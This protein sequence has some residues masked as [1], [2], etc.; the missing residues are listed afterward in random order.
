MRKTKRV[1]CVLFVLGFLLGTLPR[2]G[3]SADIRDAEQEYL[4]EYKTPPDDEPV[5]TVRATELEQLLEQDAL[6]WYEPDTELLL[7]D[8]V[9]PTERTPRRSVPTRW[10]L[11]MIGASAAVDADCIG[12]GVRVG[13]IDSG[14]AAHPDL[15]EN[16]VPG[17]NYTEGTADPSDT[18]DSY[19]HGTRVAGLISGHSESSNTGA[20]PG[21]TIVPLKCTDGKTVRVS[22]ICRAIYGGVDDFDCDILN[23]SL[24]LTA[25]YASLQEAVAY[26]RANGVLVVS[27]A[28]NGAG[29]TVYYPAGYEG[30]LG[31]GAVDQDGIVYYRSNRN[32]SV[33][34]TAPGVSVPTT[35]ALGGYTTGTGTSFAV[36]LV[37]ASAAVLMSADPS[38]TAEEI[39]AL[40]QNGAVD[41]GDEGWDSSYG[42]GIVNIENSLAC[43]RQE[44]PPD[45]TPLPAPSVFESVA[46][47][48]Q[49]EDCPMHD[50][51]DLD[52]KA[53][54]H[55]GVHFILHTGWMTGV[56]ELCFDP[57]GAA[58]RGMLAA[59]LYRA[60]NTPQTQTEV[61]PF[62]DVR[63]GKYY[64]SAVLWAA[65]SG[66][67]AGYPD[68]T[69]RPDD[70]ITREETVTMLCR[71]AASNGADTSRQAEL[72][73][74]PDAE[75][76]A[77]YARSAM[78]WAVRA[79]IVQG[80][81]GLEGQVLL[82]LK[83][84]ASRAQLA[85]MLARLSELLWN[86]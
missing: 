72:T 3:A 58:T 47:C 55:D 63:S 52:P 64:T 70:P 65:E 12:Q 77:E 67:A 76:A 24:G 68:G 84:A 74:Y 32:G 75:Q 50:F 56:G 25:D 60:Q 23:L 79:E 20:A 33:F 26:A 61:I 73:D 41:A 46:A 18:S 49:A 4:V 54:Y 15:Q 8:S 53:W 38:R 21:A 5:H 11:E 29:T 45:P 69:F 43:L 9:L 71:Y 40:L 81:T 37:T 13:V 36:P 17:W 48:A 14:V 34:L 51:A 19:G 62:S 59:V 57:G 2:V 42:F 44:N 35:Y 85:A 7:D 83:G 31:V 16:L 30:A 86:Q 28:G 22:A 27:A 10:D 82:D 1:L 80:T 78:R 66:I 6:V 39:A